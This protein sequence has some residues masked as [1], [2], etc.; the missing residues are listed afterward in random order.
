MY[1]PARKCPYCAYKSRAGEFFCVNCGQPLAGVKDD[2]VDKPDLEQAV[3]EFS[4]LVTPPRDQFSPD[5]SLVMLI[6]DVIDPLVVHPGQQTSL[7]RSGTNLE[8]PVDI[9]LTPYGAL[10]K[11]VS[12]LHAVLYR[13]D[14]DMLYL[15][16]AGSSNGTY[17]NGRRLPPNDPQALYN[18]DEVRLGKLVIHVYFEKQAKA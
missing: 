12:R 17:L 5:S 14:C 13:D 15:S 1:Q 6:R 3:R 16:D 2:T 18:G 7:G 8:H 10:Q 11:G 4:A 9:D